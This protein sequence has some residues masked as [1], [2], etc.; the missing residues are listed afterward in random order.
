VEGDLPVRF[1][2]LS[3]GVSAA[4]VGFNIPLGLAF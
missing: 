1:S 3:G 2:Q 4:S